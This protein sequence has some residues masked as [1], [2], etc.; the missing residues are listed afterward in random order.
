MRKPGVLIVK[1]TLFL[2][3]IVFEAMPLALAQP[4]QTGE[5]AHRI[6]LGKLTN[7]AEVAF[8]RAGSGG[9]GI[10]I[11]GS[12]VARE[13]QPNPA[14]IEIYRGDENVSELAAG[15]RSLRK[16]T[17]SI[18]A[19]ARVEDGGKASFTV[20]D[21]WNISGDVVSL[22]RNVSVIGA[23]QNAGFFSAIR[24]IT[25]PAVAWSDVTYLAPGLLYGDPSHDGDS[26]PGGVL[27]YRARRFEIREDLMSAPLFA[28]SFRGGGWVAVLDPA[29]RGDTTWT[30]TT[31][32]A[33]VPI[34]DERLQFGALGAREASGGGVEFGF[35]F[36]GA[37]HE[38]TGGRF[39]TATVQAVRRRYHPVKAGFSQ[40]YEVSF[41]FGKSDPFLGVERDAWRWAWQ[42][43]NPPPMHLDLDLVRRV[44]TDHLADSV[45]TVNDR[46]GIPFLF[47][48]VTGN[49]GSYRNWARYRDSFPV[50]PARPPNTPV[51]AH[52][53]SPEKSAELAAWARTVGIEVDPKANELEQWP[54][55][56]MGFVSKGIEVAESLLIEADRDP[57]SRGQHMRKEGLAIID[58]Y[59]RLVPMSP[60][61][62]E[63]FNLWT[64]KA[65]SWAGDTVTLRGPSEGVRTL[66]GCVS[67]GEAARTR[68][69][70]V[71]AMVTAVRRLAAD[72]AA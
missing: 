54:K 27:N 42:T 33:T 26:S 11:S 51:T 44:L 72:P 64:G 24:F 59:I 14:Q 45:L 70:G 35:W 63:G 40:S 37:T 62:G 29:P 25:P 61:A 60:P 7:G 3:L 34:I 68:A 10:E 39:N 55:V 2:A 6:V 48:A 22:N 9:W 58:T 52:E 67:P 30:E 38:F 16:E 1:C 12:A 31:A 23:E 53:L 66:A 13:T 5:E 19:T 47:D 49:P 57:A 56:I 20:V 71:A 69:P 15:Y 17:G 32:S 28:L 36:P 18:V 4:K 43:L 46:A 50:P 65:D 21:R 8:I 41:R